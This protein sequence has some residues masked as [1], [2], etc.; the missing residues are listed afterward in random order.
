[1]PHASGPEGKNIGRRFTL[2]DA[3]KKWVLSFAFS[4]R[5]RKNKPQRARR[6]NSGSREAHSRGRLCHTVLG[7]TAQRK[8]LTFR[9]ATAMY[10]H[11]TYSQLIRSS[12]HANVNR[13]WATSEVEVPR[14]FPLNMPPRRP[15]KYGFAL[16]QLNISHPGC[17]RNFYCL[18]CPQVM[19]VLKT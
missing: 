11:C 16:L 15:R 19:G 10:W 7:R 1:V 13:F 3:D 2:I 9:P 14:V 8:N 18:G 17:I 5:E 4:W 12:K 6:K